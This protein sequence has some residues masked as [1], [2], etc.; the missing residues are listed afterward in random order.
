MTRVQ[1]GTKETAEC[2]NRGYCDYDS[3]LCQCLTGFVGS[4]GDFPVFFS[5]LFA[6]AHACRA[7]I[8]D[9]EVGVRRDCGRTDPQGFTLN[10]Y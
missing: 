10:P 7:F 2:G 8:G 3:G 9:G 1:S 5:P 4:D 6:L